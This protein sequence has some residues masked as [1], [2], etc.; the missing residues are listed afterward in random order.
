MRNPD[1]TEAELIVALDAYFTITESTPSISQFDPEIVAASR[2]LNALEIHPHEKRTPKFRDPPGVRRR[3]NYFQRMQAGE[4]IQGR[5]AYVAVWERYKDDRDGL[6]QDAIEIAAG[7]LTPASALKPSDHE[8]IDRDIQQVRVDPA[9]K[10]TEKAAL[11]KA[12]QG[13]GRYRSNLIKLWKGCAV[14]GCRDQSLL[15]ASHLKPWSKA[16][17]SERLDSYNGLLLSPTWDRL[18]DQGLASLEENGKMLLSP[19]LS[20]KDRTAL[21]VSIEAKISI[22]EHHLPYVRHHRKFEFKT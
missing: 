3:F 8:T 4:Q 6:R 5:S 17:N 21:G 11:I 7:D 18:F 1:W 9:L 16:T 2:I 12:R 10:P 22:C 13:Q 20:S 14:T 15:V 19:Y